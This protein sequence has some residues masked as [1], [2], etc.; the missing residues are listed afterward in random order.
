MTNRQQRVLDYYERHHFPLT[1]K[2]T[3]ELGRYSAVTRDVKKGEIILEDYPYVVT[4]DDRFNTEVCAHCFKVLRGTK[5]TTKCEKCGYF[6]YCSEK[7]RQ[8]DDKHFP[9]ECQALPKFGLL[10]AHH[11]DEMRL[12]ARVLLRCVVKGEYEKEQKNLNSE[13]IFGDVNDLISN[14]ELLSETQ[15]KEYSEIGRAVNKSIWGEDTSKY[16]K[17]EDLV[18]ILSQILCNAYSYWFDNTTFY[19]QGFYI[20]GSYLNHSCYPSSFKYDEESTAKHTFLASRD[21]KAG[22]AFTYSY[23]CLNDSLTRRRQ[24]TLYYYLFTC[25]CERCVAEEKDPHAFDKFVD[26]NVCKT[27]TCAGGVINLP[28]GI[29]IRGKSG[30][31][32]CICGANTPNRLL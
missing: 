8:N 24:D 19:V 12:P 15:I 21:L 17:V 4:V 13:L 22:E 18:I 6:H 23:I 28:E 31:I 10:I 32:C 30:K 27:P 20:I 3:P 25:R 1:I 5:L 11:S 2:S 7:C 29:T 16:K 26:E 9:L 14:V